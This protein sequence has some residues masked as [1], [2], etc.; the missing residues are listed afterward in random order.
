MANDIKT[1]LTDRMAGFQSFSMAL[2]ESTDLSD[3]AQPVIFIRGVDKEFT[4]TEELLALQP[5]RGTIQERTFLLKFKRHLLYRANGKAD[6]IPNLVST[7]RGRSAA[8]SRLALAAL[9][10]HSPVLAAVL[11][12]EA[13]P[14]RSY[15]SKTF[16]AEALTPIITTPSKSYPI[17][18]ISPNLTKFL[19]QFSRDQPSEV[20]TGSCRRRV[21]TDLQTELSP[22]RSAPWI[23]FT[24]AA[25]NEFLATCGQ[26]DGQ[27]L[28]T[29]SLSQ[30]SFMCG[31]RSTT[32][33]DASI[34]LQ[35]ID[36]ASACTYELH[37]F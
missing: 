7:G 31:G 11:A 16:T 34:P 10:L 5:L 28:Q 2:D 17:K 35:F 1:T 13:L 32:A 30:P 25:E 37:T 26:N 8:E 15:L 29:T 4:V 27:G 36:G 24:V 18:W 3:T 19:S 23:S 9:V 21:P 22:R 33:T 6:L 12:R 20:T 14:F